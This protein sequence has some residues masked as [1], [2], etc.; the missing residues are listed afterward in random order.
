M[1]GCAVYKS[2][3]HLSTDVRS[4]FASL[5]Q[6]NNPLNLTLTPYLQKSSNPTAHLRGQSSFP[7]FCGVRS[8]LLSFFRV[9]SNFQRCHVSPSHHLE[10][11]SVRPLAFIHSRESLTCQ[12]PSFHQFQNLQVT[13]FH[14]QRAI[15]HPSRLPL[16]LFT[17][18]KVLTCM[19]SVQT[20]EGFDYLTSQNPNCTWIY[21]SGSNK[22]TN[23]S[24]LARSMSSYDT[25]QTSTSKVL[26]Y[27]S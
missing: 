1:P 27:V 22:I 15:K 6:L 23:N 4:I 11:L 2:L 12:V 24:V 20:S 14:P 26:I 21:F 7:C 17:A 18:V 13:S 19:I 9:L 5:K 16:F 25:L 3:T 8:L 10:R